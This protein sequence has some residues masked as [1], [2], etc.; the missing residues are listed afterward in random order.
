EG[1]G[2]IEPE[3][4]R[5]H[6]AVCEG[7]RPPAA[8]GTAVKIVLDFQSQAAQ[9]QAGRFRLSVTNAAQPHGT[10]TLPDAIA[11]LLRIPAEKRSDAQRQELRLDHRKQPP[12][13]L[14]PLPQKPAKLQQPKL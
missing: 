1:G 3:G 10:R 13:P 12:T 5:P 7:E 9:H 4:G 2:G 14:K 11:A 6:R 8:R